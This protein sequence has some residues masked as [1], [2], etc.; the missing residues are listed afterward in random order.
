MQNLFI[1]LLTLAIFIIAKLNFMASNLFSFGD[2]RNHPHRSGFDLSRRICFTSKAGELLPVYY[3]LVYPGDKFQIRHQLFTRTQPVNTAAYTRIRE[4][5][6]W[7]FVPLRLINKN[8]PQ[9]LMNMQNNPV[10]ASGIG[11][12][13]I[14]TND[15]PYCA[16]GAFGEGYSENIF[17]LLHS[18]YKGNTAISL[19]VVENFFGFNA[20]TCGAKLAMMLRYGNFVPPSFTGSS[21]NELNL[22]LS[23]NPSFSLQGINTHYSV[24]VL[25]FAAYQ[26]IYA[27]HFRISQWESNEPYTYNFDW[28]SGGPVFQSLTGSSNS[29]ALKEYLKGNNLFTLRYANW[30]KDLFMGVMPNSQLGDVSVVDVLPTSSDSPNLI[31][32]VVGVTVDNVNAT[33]LIAMNGTSEPGVFN[34][35]PARTPQTDAVLR[36]VISN[37]SL[38]ASFS[39]LQLRMA[40]A[41]QRYREVSQ[42]ADQTARDQ[43]Y[44]H[45]GVTLSPALSDT[46]F[47]I[48]GSASNIDISEVVNTF[49]GPDTE[50]EANIKGKGV[51]T[52]QGGTSFSSDEYGILMAIYHVVP[53]L[54]YVITGQPQDLL[55]T[56]TADLP[57]P[58]FDSIGMQSLHFGRFFNYK[59]AA[60]TSDPTRSVMGYVPRF[61]DL[62]TDYDEVYG[63]FRS[64]LKSWVAPLDPEY[65]SK[66]VSST[67]LPGESAPTYSLNYGFF[68]VNPSVLDS[69]FKVKADSSMDTDQFLSSL[70]LDV[71]AVRNFDYDGMPY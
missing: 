25:P 61:I 39:V 31:G 44:A 26:K 60:F 51:G 43:I 66:W 56:N 10:Q 57:F 71:K 16:L 40:E 50:T 55:Y 59:T 13:K 67:I 53:L 15:I 68:K 2:V 28:Y 30:P 32:D 69:I 34:M 49:L 24:N 14:V 6:D 35:R 41:V 65:L 29:A 45:F 63:A 7:Y 5:L 37:P 48:G 23:T 11:T 64:T 36:A 33:G 1:L 52:G 8:L 18:M 62:K 17:T 3:K 4:Y 70:Y 21:S 38:Q 58:E 19:P 20:G 12:N 46:C 42:V 47:R 54:D 27:D 9:A 22:G